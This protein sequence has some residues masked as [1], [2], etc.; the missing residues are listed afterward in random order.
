M[1]LIARTQSLMMDD[2]ILFFDQGRR[3]GVFCLPKYTSESVDLVMII[4]LSLFIV[5]AL[6]GNTLQ[7]PFLTRTGGLLTYS[8]FAQGIKIGIML[9]SR[10]GMTVQ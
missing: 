9:P 4:A 8:K 3:H 6:T 5:I 7:I 10:I 1:R 2:D